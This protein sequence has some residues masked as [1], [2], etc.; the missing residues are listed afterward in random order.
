MDILGVTQLHA[1][2]S[3]LEALLGG[4]LGAGFHFGGSRGTWGASLVV[5]WLRIRLQMQGTQVRALV[6]EDPTCRRTTKP[7]CHSY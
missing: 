3:W 6:R 1:D 2:L 5:Q 4:V 7:V